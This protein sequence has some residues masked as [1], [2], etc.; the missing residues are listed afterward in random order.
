MALVSVS[1]VCVM[2]SQ[3]VAGARPIRRCVA[4]G[5]KPIPA[6]LTLFLEGDAVVHHPTVT[7]KWSGKPLPR[8]CDGAHTVVAF[9]ARVRFPKVGHTLELG[10]GENS[11]W[12]TFWLGRTRV[13]GA[14]RG[15]SGPDV[16]FNL[17]CVE[18]P[19]AWLRYEVQA[20]GGR[21]LARLVR[22]VPLHSEICQR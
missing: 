6:R 14:E 2:L 17:G 12:D 21:V 10:P 13:E 20:R 19:R 7:V 9:R 1:V 18:K 5:L 4:L 16:T 8:G 15:D 11:R 22:A 3:T